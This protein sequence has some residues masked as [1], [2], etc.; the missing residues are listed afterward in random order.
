MTRTLA[1]AVAALSLLAGACHHYA[2]GSLAELSPGDR[3]RA[4]LTQEQVRAFDEVLPAGERRLEGT[5][6]EADGGSVLLE[7]PVLTVAEGIRLDSYHQRLRI[8]APGLADVEVRALARGRTYALVGV[9]GVVVG[10]IVWNQ[11]GGARR[12]STNPPDPPN[13]DGA[14]VVRLGFVFD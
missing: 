9:A 11:L 6:L 3:V 13:E 8:Q 4:L 7:V 12:G 5:V 10:A 14:V 1:L 2:P